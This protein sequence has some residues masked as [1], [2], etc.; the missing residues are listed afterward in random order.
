MPLTVRLADETGE[1]DVVFAGNMALSSTRLRQGQ[2]V[3]VQ[4]ITT[5]RATGEG[6]RAVFHV[7]CDAST[8]GRVTVVSALNGLLHTTTQIPWLEHCAAFAITNSAITAVCPGLAPAQVFSSGVQAGT[9]P[10]LLALPPSNGTV[11]LVHVLC[12]Q[13][14][15]QVHDTVYCSTCR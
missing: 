5:T 4:G 9:H 15:V 1:C 12:H 7:E 6:G 11:M 2:L 3:L 10:L 13:P 14:V 8:G